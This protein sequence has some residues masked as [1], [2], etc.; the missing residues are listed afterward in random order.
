MGLMFSVVVANFFLG[1]LGVILRFSSEWCVRGGRAC[2]GG[3]ACG[4]MSFFVNVCM[5]RSHTCIHPPPKPD[6]RVAYTYT[7]QTNHPKTQGHRHARVLR[8]GQLDG[9]VPDGAVPRPAAPLVRPLPP[10]PPRLLDDGCVYAC[11]YGWMYSCAYIYKCVSPSRAH[12][13]KRPTALHTKQTN[14]QTQG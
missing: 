3:W 1:C 5:T 4:W 9:P 12:E 7:P 6:P 2:V 13:T 11:V 14:E 8:G 10:R